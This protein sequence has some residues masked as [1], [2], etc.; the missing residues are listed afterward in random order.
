M[1]G[2]TASFKRNNHKRVD[3]QR[4]EI[5][6]VLQIWSLEAIRLIHALSL[7]SS[8]QQH[9]CGLLQ[10][11]HLLQIS[12]WTPFSRIIS[13]HCP[14][15]E[16]RTA[17]PQADRAKS[18]TASYWSDQLLERD[19]PESGL[20]EGVQARLSTETDRGTQAPS[21]LIRDL[22]HDRPP[23]LTPRQDTLHAKIPSTSLSRNCPTAQRLRTVLEFLWTRQEKWPL[24]LWQ[25]STSPSL[26]RTRPRPSHHSISLPHKTNR[27]VDSRGLAQIKVMAT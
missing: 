20:K 4:A 1:D 7:P 25:T 18:A 13:S 21:N 23:P 12:T 5:T 27:A 26:N 16:S 6:A 2:G 9:L 19:L 14:E 10:A 8:Q 22:S 11:L 3:P 17:G 24:M 15:K